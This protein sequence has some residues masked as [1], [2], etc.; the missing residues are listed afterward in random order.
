MYLVFICSKCCITSNHTTVFI[1]LH[2]IR[3]PIRLYNQ[4]ECLIFSLVHFLNKFKIEVDFFN[5]KGFY[6]EK[7]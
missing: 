5:L 4:Y 3:L 1:F 7:I 6:N 2:F